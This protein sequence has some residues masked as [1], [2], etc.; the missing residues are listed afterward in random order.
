MRRLG[1]LSFLIACSAAFAADRELNLFAWSEYVPQAVLDGFT[2]ETGIAVRYET[3]SS[4]EEM[5]SKLLAG[6]SAYDLIQPPDYIAE[7]LI[8]HGLLARLEFS[9]LPNF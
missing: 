5:L 4:G 1:F 2:A 3:F 9:R 6:A 7:A 8:K